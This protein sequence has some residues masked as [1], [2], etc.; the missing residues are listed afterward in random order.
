MSSWHDKIGKKTS[1][2]AL[3]DWI[4][5]NAQR[6][7]FDGESLQKSRPKLSEFERGVDE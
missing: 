5:S 4:V 6:L 3:V 1:G 7:E 2:D